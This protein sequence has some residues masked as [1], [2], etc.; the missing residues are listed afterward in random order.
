[1]ISTTVSLTVQAN[2]TRYRSGSGESV[3]NIAAAHYS[4]DA[5]AWVTGTLTYS[6][7]AL[8]GAFNT[9]IE[10][11]HAT[12]SLS[13]LSVGRHILFVE[14]QDATGHWGPPTAAFVW[15]IPGDKNLYLPI[16]LR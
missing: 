10:S 3:Q 15:I 12:V 1:L 6:L 16:T 8:D 4:I 13:G 2:D 9:P 11:L 7:S 14:S 5:P